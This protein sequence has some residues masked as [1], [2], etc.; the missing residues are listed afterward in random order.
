MVH[1]IKYATG[2]DT[3]NCNKFMYEFKSYMPFNSVM[4]GFSEKVT[5]DQLRKLAKEKFPTVSSIRRVEV[6]DDMNVSGLEQFWD[7]EIDFFGKILG[8]TGNV[9]EGIRIALQR[10]TK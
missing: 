5:R 9:S 8:E 2:I 1:E 3:I 6:D 4:V 7:V 10:S